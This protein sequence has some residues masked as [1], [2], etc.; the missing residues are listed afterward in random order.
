MTRT[1]PLLRAICGVLLL[2]VIGYT[3]AHAKKLRFR[4]L[5]K[6]DKKVGL[7]V[8]PQE[9]VAIGVTSSLHHFAVLLPYS[10][11]W[12]LESTA[13][14]PLT[15]EDKTYSVSMRSVK[16]PAAGIRS[17]LEEVVGRLKSANAVAK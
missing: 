11:S 17:Y 4:G 3:P 9:R 15:A 13:A 8:V 14:T 7:I 1:G 10:H 5:T 2:S 6:F 16:I 12:V